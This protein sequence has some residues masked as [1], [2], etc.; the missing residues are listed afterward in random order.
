VTPTTG[1]GDAFLEP[2]E[3]ARV[4]IPAMNVGDG[5]ATGVNVTVSTGDSQAAITPHAQS[6]G[7]IAAGATATRNFTLALHRGYPLGKPVALTVRVTFAGVLSPTMATQRLST[8]QP[9]TTATTFAYTGPPVAIPDD[10]DVG[11]SVAIP[12]TGLGY[13]SKLTFSVDGATCTAA[14]GATTVGI[15]HTFVGD[16]TGTLT[17]PS[18]ASAV[19]FQ[20]SGGGGNNMCQV[21]FDDAA[22][23]PF[24]GV[25]ASRAP[26]TGT[27][28]PFQPLI[29]LLDGSAD[30]NWT[31]KVTDG[32]ALDTGSLRAVTIELTG[33]VTG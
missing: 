33:F 18:G 10:S 6:Y 8:G 30:G 1:D 9:A 26:F 16:L 31:F 20:R 21:V 13:A 11:A 28:K 7:S 5:A 32:A 23:T 29:S 15:D 2:G 19:V 12:V 27:W 17:S 24:V 14:E 4:S 3:N 25:L 22:T